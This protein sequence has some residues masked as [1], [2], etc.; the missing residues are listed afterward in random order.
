MQAVA[1]SNSYFL[2]NSEDQRWKD[3]KGLFGRMQSQGLL[4]NVGAAE[5]PMHISETGEN[6]WLELPDVKGWDY[7]IEKQDIVDSYKAKLKSID[8]KHFDFGNGNCPFGSSC[9]YK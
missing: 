5:V 4:P 8:C 2:T 1:A 9:F 6:G 3:E 7:H